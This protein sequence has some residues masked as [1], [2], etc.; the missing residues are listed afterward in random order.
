MQ[1]QI[2]IQNPQ[3]SPRHLQPG[4]APADQQEALQPSYFAYSGQ[5][6]S[7]LDEEGFHREPL[8]GTQEAPMAP[9][10]RAIASPVH[11]A[12]VSALRPAS[13]APTSRLTGAAAGAAYGTVLGFGT[14]LVLP[15]L[16]LLN[17]AGP[18]ALMYPRSWPGLALYEFFFAVPAA[19]CL[20]VPA[21]AVG[22][23]WGT[24]WGIG[25]PDEAVERL[26]NLKEDW[27]HR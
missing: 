11:C 23:A 1:M 5:S 15:L 6:T 17:P 10:H 12:G 22:G 13:K 21:M 3:L 20:E 26:F 27:L 9:V 7:S 14:P 24:V 25:H 4:A 16:P 18:F 8:Q 19:L 2:P